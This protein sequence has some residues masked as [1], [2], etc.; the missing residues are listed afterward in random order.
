MGHCRGA[1]RHRAPK[2]GAKGYAEK[3]GSRTRA[4][5]RARKGSAYSQFERRA[6]GR[7]TEQRTP[8]ADNEGKASGFPA[9]QCPNHA[10]AEGRTAAG[11][12]GCQPRT[13]SS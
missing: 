13:S 12:Q 2:C 11:N 3:R 1:V 4:R 9:L 5:T 10:G 8:C 6:P 7:N